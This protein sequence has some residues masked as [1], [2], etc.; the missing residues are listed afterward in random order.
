MLEQ[1]RAFKDRK[2]SYVRIVTGK[3]A[4]EKLQNTKS[5]V[6]FF[7]FCFESISIDEWLEGNTPICFNGYPEWFLKFF[8]QFPNNQQ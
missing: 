8:L 2:I 1:W 3:N 7:L 5:A 4:S 6:F